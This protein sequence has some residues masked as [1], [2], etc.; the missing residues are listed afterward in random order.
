MRRPKFGVAA[1]SIAAAAY[2][3]P[4]KAVAAEEEVNTLHIDEIF[5]TASPILRDRFDVVQGTSVLSGER[6]A[7]ALRSSIGETL[8]SQPGVTSTFFGPYASR[9]IIRGFDGDRIRVLFDGIGSIDASS[10]SPDHETAGD[11]LGAERV[12]VLRGPATL[13]YGTSAIG[14]VVNII[15]GRIPLELPSRGYHAHLLGGYGTNAGERFVSGAGDIHVGGGLMLHAGGNWRKTDEYKIP[16]YASEEAEE[17]GIEG[18]V[19]NTD[20]RTASGTGGVSYV[21]EKGLMGASVQHF[22]SNY[23]VAGHAH[24]EE[25]EGA[26]EPHHEETLVRVDLAQTRLD[27]K[28]ELN[29]LGSFITSVRTRAAFGDYEHRELEGGD[30]GTVFTNKG[31]EGRIEAIHAP[32]GPLNGILGVQFRKRDFA[33]IGDEAFTPPSDTRQ[34]AGFLLES[35]EFGDLRFEAGARVEDTRIAL[36]DGTR[37][38]FTSSAF[39]GSAAYEFAPETLVGLTASWT[40]RPPTAE[41]LFSDGPH[42][43]TN[44]FEV[45]NPDLGE[46]RAKNVELTLRRGA[47]VLTGSISLYRTWYDR[48]IFA[49]ATGGEEDGLPIFEF[50][51]TDARFTGFESEVAIQA[52]DAPEFGVAFD[53][54][55]DMVRATDVTRG[56]PLP[57]IP[58]LRV[59]VGVESRWREFDGR[60]ELAL[61]DGQ[62]RIARLES[63]TEGY[64]FLNA[65]IGFRPLPSEDIQLV[66]Q[67]QNLTNEKARQ[68]T[69]FLK[70]L[71][72]LPGRDVRLYLR[73]A[74]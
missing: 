72:P 55:L 9:P 53:A 27:L 73:A 7:A 4:G 8:S 30:V 43:A 37:R 63:A 16:G 68:H 25:E 33:A 45:G 23:G 11:A 59:R 64:A 29:G 39:S 18:K 3:S 20:G 17:E 21:W 65:R 14:G 58:P 12:E 70:E 69:S 40:E 60:V 74:F 50:G 34:L 6:L 35:A 62:S 38:S 22:E 36:E 71:A 66:L 56:E 19:E 15:D 1:L 5:I 61:T 54:A 57:R 51:E 46:E 13:L 31:W 47:G 49:A 2:I 67:G 24:H 52:I 10:V 41:E 48:F 44:Q 26:A 28:G 42:L 32:V